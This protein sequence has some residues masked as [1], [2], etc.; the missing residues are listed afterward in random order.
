MAQIVVKPTTFSGKSNEDPQEWFTQ[1]ERVAGANNWNDAAK[2]RIV[3]A[4]L[5]G[6][7]GRWFAQAAVTHWTGGGN[8]RD[9]NFDTAFANR[10]ITAGSKNTW[11]SKL[12]SLRQGAMDI[13]EFNDKFT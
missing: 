3:P 5:I 11:R 2:L 9:V 7:A 8:P 1:F 13:E 10:F 12:H 6:A 4:Y